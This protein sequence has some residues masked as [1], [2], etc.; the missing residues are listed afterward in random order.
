[1]I[2]EVIRLIAERFIEEYREE[3]SKILDLWEYWKLDEYRSYHDLYEI[4]TNYMDSHLW[5]SNDKI[6]DLFEK[7]KYQV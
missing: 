1:M 6:Q 3:V 4:Y 5:F 7:S 2:Y